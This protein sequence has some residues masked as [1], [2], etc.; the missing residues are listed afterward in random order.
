MTVMQK[1][2]SH[3]DFALRAFFFYYRDDLDGRVEIV[4]ERIKRET[5]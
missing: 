3:T 1:N 2:H 4:N 5:G